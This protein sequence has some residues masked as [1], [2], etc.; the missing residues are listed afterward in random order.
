[1]E[2]CG[3]YARVKSALIQ[4]SILPD[5]KRRK[6]SVSTVS[7]RASNIQL[8]Y[9]RIYNINFAMHVS[10]CRN[11]CSF[12]MESLEVVPNH[13]G[14][15]P[16]KLYRPVL[17]VL[18]KIH[19][20]GDGV[21]AT[22]TLCRCVVRGIG[23]IDPIFLQRPAKRKGGISAN[24]LLSGAWREDNYISSNISWGLG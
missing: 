17:S 12:D 22:L 14:F 10:G 9:V 16:H 7:S 11:R 6:Q 5:I 8:S 15:N 2:R 4:Q 19:T 18:T 13:R 20:T 3:S 21:R 1:M 23:R 24:F